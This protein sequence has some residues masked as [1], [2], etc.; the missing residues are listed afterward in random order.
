[1]DFRRR[2]RTVFQ[3]RN[4]APERCLPV[5]VE[6]AAGAGDLLSMPLACFIIPTLTAQCTRRLWYALVGCPTR[7]ALAPPCLGAASP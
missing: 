7:R 4:L 6:A 3:K 5:R 2:P 1:V